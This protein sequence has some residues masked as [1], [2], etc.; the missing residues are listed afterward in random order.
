MTKQQVFGPLWM[1]SNLRVSKSKASNSDTDIRFFCC[2]FNSTYYMN[3]GDSILS[4][5]KTIFSYFSTKNI[6]CG[7][8]AVRAASHLPG[9]GPTDVDDAPAPAC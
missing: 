2:F 7:H 1:V 9:K 6:C 4:V 8:S 5:I 3:P